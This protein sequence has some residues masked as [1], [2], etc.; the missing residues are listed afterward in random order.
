MLRLARALR[1]YALVL[2][3]LALSACYHTRV[4]TGAR[5][6]ATVIDQPFALGFVY[7]IVPPPTVATAAQCPQGV[8]VVETQQSLIN[9]L[10][11]VLTIGLVTPMQI[12]V[13]CAAEGSAAL[14]DAPADVIV[15]ANASRG[16][17][18]DAVAQA[19]ELAVATSAPAVVQFTR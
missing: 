4:E 17:V 9:G 13:T 10:V 2:P 16:D 1:V 8:A 11:S 5:P 14:L 19:A 6:G 3:A 18:Q 15:D 12:T 7:G